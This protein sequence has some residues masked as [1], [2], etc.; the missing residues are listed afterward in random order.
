MQ[1]IIWVH[2]MFVV[3]RQKMTE[4]DLGVLDDDFCETVYDIDAL[5]N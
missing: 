3:Y 2:F 4:I 5:E 1:V